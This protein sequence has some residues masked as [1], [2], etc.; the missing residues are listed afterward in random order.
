MD[1][2]TGIIQSLVSD[3]HGTRAV[4]EVDV[5]TACPRCAAGKGCGAGLLLGSSRLRRVEAS[6]S[7]EL[8]LV[9]GDNVEI[10]LTPINLLQA[11]LT[12][13]GLP[14]LGALAGAGLAYVMVLGDAA[15]AS[16]AILGLLGGLLVGRWRL[17]YTACLER[18]VPR[19]EKRLRS[20]Q[21]GL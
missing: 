9:E 7:A 2:P 18:F 21:T 19:I 8:R 17:R 4:V 5:S 3:A 11:A 13:Y 10:A 1:N 20:A 16:A 6:F 15:A 12:V 14:L